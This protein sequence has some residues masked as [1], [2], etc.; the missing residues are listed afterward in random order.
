M[1]PAHLRS[2]AKFITEDM[3]A[4]YVMIG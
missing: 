2:H 3:L 4:H 1:D